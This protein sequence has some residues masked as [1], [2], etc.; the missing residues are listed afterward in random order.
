MT[1]LRFIR[2]TYRQ[3]LPMIAAF[4]VVGVWALILEVMK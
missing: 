2:A 3:G 4:A 1:A